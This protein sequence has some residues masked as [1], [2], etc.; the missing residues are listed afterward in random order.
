MA[1]RNLPKGMTRRG[2]TYWADFFTHG[3]RVRQSLSGDFRVARELLTELRARANRADFGLLDNNVPLEDLRRQYV[4][5]CRQV[6]KPGTVR[7]YE[8]SLAAILPHV[9]KRVAQL[10]ADAMLDYRERRLAEGVSPRTVNI[11]VD[12]LA[13]LLRWAV[14][15]EKIGSNPIDGLGPLPHDH[16]KEGRALEPGEVDR[17]LDAS[18]QPWRDV[19][20]AFLVT[21]MRKAELAAL[22]FSD[23]DWDARELNV[24]RGVSKTHN[25]RRIPIDPGLWEILSKLEDARSHRRAGVSTD[26]AERFTRNHVFTTTHSTPLNGT[27]IYRRLMRCYHL[28]GIPTR[29]VDAEGHEIDHLDVHSLRK[30]FATDLIENGTDPKTVQELLGHKT[31]AVT[32]QLYAKIRSGSKHAAVAKLSYGQA[33]TSQKP[34]SNPPEGQKTGPPR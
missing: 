5:H 34:H 29:R 18:P 2:K 14:K 10:T 12:T 16:P 22:T 1:K 26:L 24:R 9:P 4:R 3:R 19:W 27:C 28:A 21:G 23:I 6:N 25:A 32:M 30:T 15:R 11:D 7:R 13:R 33:K 8:Y 17:L 31:L 20:Y